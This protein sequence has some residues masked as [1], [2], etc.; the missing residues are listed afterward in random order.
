MTNTKRNS[1]G[2]TEIEVEDFIEQFKQIALNK[3]YNDT[4][5][6]KRAILLY[7]AVGLQ[8]FLEWNTGRSDRLDERMKALTRVEEVTLQLKE[9]SIKANIERG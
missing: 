9:L 4:D 5:A 6:R 7:T 8:R 1:L 3:G 2:H